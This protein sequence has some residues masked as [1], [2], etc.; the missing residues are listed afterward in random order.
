MNFLTIRNSKQGLKWHF[1]LPLNTVTKAVASKGFLQKR[2]DLKG[3]FGAI[4]SKDFHF[5]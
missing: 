1:G 4:S 5:G 3:I 2:S